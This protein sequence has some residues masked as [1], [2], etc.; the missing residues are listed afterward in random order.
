MENETITLNAVLDIWQNEQNQEREIDADS[1]SPQQLI[2]LKK[3]ISQ[4]ISQDRN[5]IE[6]KAYYQA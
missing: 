2:P 4:R 3:A 5:K 1:L 6:E